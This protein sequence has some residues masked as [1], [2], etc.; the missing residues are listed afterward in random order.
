MYRRKWVV[1]VSKF[2]PKPLIIPVNFKI[3]CFLVVNFVTE[4]DEK[5]ANS[6]EEAT[7][8]GDSL[9]NLFS[10][11][12]SL[13]RKIKRAEKRTDALIEKDTDIV[14]NNMLV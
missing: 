3:Y 8:N 13:Q 9:E 14:E 4:V 10:R 11:R 7:K 12:R 6:I 1:V 5:L 2:I